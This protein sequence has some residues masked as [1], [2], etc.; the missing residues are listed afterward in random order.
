MKKILL[1]LGLSTMSLFTALACT[2][3]ASENNSEA[4]AQTETNYEI[5]RAS[6]RERV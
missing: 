2:A 4:Q 6:C 3:H 1:T 5:G